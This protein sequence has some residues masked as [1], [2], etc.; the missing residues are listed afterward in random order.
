[1]HLFT[2]VDIYFILIRLSA[3][4]GHRFKGHVWRSIECD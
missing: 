4:Q 3:D 2:S 1:M